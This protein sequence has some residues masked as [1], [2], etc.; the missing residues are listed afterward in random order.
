MSRGRWVGFRLSLG[1]GRRICLRGCDLVRGGVRVHW[2]LGRVLGQGPVLVLELGL[3]L[4]LAEGELEELGPELGLDEP[5][6]EEPGMELE[7]EPDRPEAQEPDTNR[8]KQ[9]IHYTPAAEAQELDTQA[10]H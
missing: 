2:V 7:P 5:S 9:G 6:V 8:R 10:A 1:F 3:G 4:A